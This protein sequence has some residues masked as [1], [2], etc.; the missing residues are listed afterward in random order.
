MRVRGARPSWS[1]E[2]LALEERLDAVEAFERSQ[3]R[4]RI[5]PHARGYVFPVL[6]WVMR[7]LI[8][9]ALGMNVAVVAML[10]TFFVFVKMLHITF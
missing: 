3:V 4:R 8:A 5:A 10:V 7:A 9:I 1:P 2:R 6:G